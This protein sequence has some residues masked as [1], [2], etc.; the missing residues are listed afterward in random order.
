MRLAGLPRLRMAALPTP[1]QHAPRLSKE[2]GVDVLI[3]RTVPGGAA[4]EP[5][6]AMIEHCRAAVGELGSWVARRRRE[7]DRAEQALLEVHA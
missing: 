5:M 3:K 1:L 2:L 4:A 6:A 7:A